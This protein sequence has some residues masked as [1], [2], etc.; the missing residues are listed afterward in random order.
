MTLDFGYDFHQHHGLE[1]PK[2]DYIKKGLCGLINMGNTCFLNATLQ[3]LMHTLK[4][5]DYFLTNKHFTDDIEHLIR[6][7]PEYTFLMSYVRLVN[8]Y[9]ETNQLIK[10][11]SFLDKVRAHFPKYN[12]NEQHDSHECFLHI[13]DLLH[14]SISYPIDV[15]I[16][17]EVK[18]PKDALMKASL[19]CWKTTYEKSY[20]PIIDIFDGMTVNTVVCTSCG[21]INNVFESFNNIS[22]HP[23][24]LANGER[25]LR[26]CFNDNY[27]NN[28]VVSTWSCEKCKKSGCKVSSKL[29]TLPNVLVLHLNRFDRNGTKFEKNDTHVS[30][31]N[32]IDLTQYISTDKGDPNNYIYSLYAVNYH[33]GTL[34]S[35][36]YWAACKNLDGKWY[37]YDDGDVVRSKSQKDDRNAYMLFYYR[38]MIP[39]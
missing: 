25:S 31:P 5:S 19:E 7:K 22:L 8:N 28:Q 17:G 16:N 2:K 11:K 29:W 36:H 33:K 21:D 23:G 3:C 30:F 27:L 9:W 32:E 14:K 34:N 6:R 24:D 10:P 18:T 35:G 15:S 4:L 12:G 37:T 13:V 39:S 38:K 26:D 20:S 1:R